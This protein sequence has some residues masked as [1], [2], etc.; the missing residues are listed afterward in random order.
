MGR[1]KSA[2]KENC[3]SKEHDAIKAATLASVKKRKEYE[4]DKKFIKVPC[5]HGYILKEFKDEN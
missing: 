3:L 2:N 5:Y 1:A 4:K